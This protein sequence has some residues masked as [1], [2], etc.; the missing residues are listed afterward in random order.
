MKG[1]L[2]QSKR[3]VLHEPRKVAIYLILGLRGE[4]LDE[5][6]REFHLK[7]YSSASSATERVKVQMSRDRQVKGRVEKL[8]SVLTKSQTKTWPLDNLMISYTRQEYF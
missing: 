1:D 3:A 4:G 5:I 6:Y 7:R 8:I 2:L